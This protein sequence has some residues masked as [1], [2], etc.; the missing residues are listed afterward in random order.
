[1]LNLKKIIPALL[2]TAN[3]L[4]CA[5][6]PIKVEKFSDYAE[7]KKGETAR[8]FWDFKNA[9]RVIISGISQE[10]AAVDSAALTPMKTEF[11]TITAYQEALAF[12]FFRNHT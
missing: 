5:Q 9:D 1:M 7:I 2:L 11:Y 8:I 10:Y 12:H 3:I 6:P 4:P